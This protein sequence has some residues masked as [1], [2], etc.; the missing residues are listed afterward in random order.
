MLSGRG[1]YRIIGFLGVLCLVGCDNFNQS[2]ESFIYTQTG[3]VLPRGAAAIVSPQAAPDADGAFHILAAPGA[4]ADIV[5]ELGL[6]ND[7]GYALRIAALNNGAASDA[8]TAEQTGPDRV[9]IR[10]AAAKPGDVY[11]IVLE[12]KTADGHRSFGDIKLP[13]VY[14]EARPADGKKLLAFDFDAWTG[15]VAEG[16]QTV[17]VTVSYGTEISG[18]TPTVTVSPGADYS[19]KE[20]WGFD[21]SD[22]SKTYRVTA[23]DGTTADYVVTVTVADV[24]AKKITGFTLAGVA[25]TITDTT[26]TI[27]LTVPYGTAITNIAPDITHTG[28]SIA[29]AADMPQNFTTQQTYRVTA[30]DG[31]TADYTVTVTVAAA[32]VHNITIDPYPSAKGTVIASV[33]GTTAIAAVAGETVTLTANPADGYGP[34]AGTLQVNGAAVTVSGSGPY[35]FVMPA[36]DVTVTAEF[37]KIDDSAVVAQRGTTLYASLKDAIEAAA[38]TA[39]LENP[40]VIILLRDITLP[41]P[42]AGTTGHTIAKQHIKLTSGSGAHT[43]TRKSG[44]AG[45]LFTVSGASLTLAGSPYAL[46]IDGNSVTAS[47]PLITVSGGTLKMHDGVI[48]RNNKNTDN[49]GGVYVRLNSTFAMSG[50][51]IGGNTAANGGGVFVSDAASFSMTAGTIAGNS[52]PHGAGVYINKGTFAMSGGIITGNTVSNGG[53]GGVCMVGGSSQFKIQGGTIIGNTA[54]NGGGVYMKDGTFTMTAGFITGNSASGNGGGVNI[55]GGTFN[56]S[57]SA[58]IDSNRVYLATGK[59]ITLTGDMTGTTPVA[60]IHP[61]TTESGT[62]VLKGTDLLVKNNEAKFGL[63]ILSTTYTGDDNHIDIDGTITSP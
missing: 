53:G 47:A 56:M 5:V 29:P 60:V 27:T 2:I 12:I 6:E 46:V 43:I 22:I 20:P 13:D 45:S 11:R 9:R 57:G 30:A 8:V 18:I 28:A 63:Y 3:T 17:A 32:R 48:L 35:T 41:E 15:S 62:P 49:G 58:T 21:V 39:S 31:T 16:A 55:S 10:I 26:G 24:A 54:S 34:K 59:F 42:E 25:G 33:A 40:D 23:A 14:C 36:T 51:T 44:F 7:R 52:A 4:A 50:G 37:I 38:P 19:P 1:I 61:Q